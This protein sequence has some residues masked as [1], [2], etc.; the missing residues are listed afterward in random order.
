MP[1]LN[2]ITA[3]WWLFIL[4]W[5]VSA[6]AVKPLK[7]RPIRPWRLRMLFCSVSVFLLLRSGNSV[8]FWPLSATVWFGGCALT[9]AGLAIA[10]WARW[11]LGTNWSAAVTFRE[12]QE[13]VQRGPYRRVRHPIY[14]GVL[15]MLAGTALVLANGG[16]LLAVAVMSL[17]FG[18][19]IKQE[20]ALMLK[21][22]PDAYSA[23]R[24]RTKA[25]IP[26]L[27]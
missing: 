8:R 4:F 24:A 7:E 10:I 26:F 20:E 6:F 14:T 5:V 17:C 9:A 11:V 12:G 15:L 22:F 3:C 27:F 2:F 21:H 16:I 13:L 19:R 1:H 23:Y 18:W 25:L